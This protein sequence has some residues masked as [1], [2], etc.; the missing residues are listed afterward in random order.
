MNLFYFKLFIFFYVN[1]YSFVL[2]SFGFWFIFLR[3][4]HP[5][6]FISEHCLYLFLFFPLGSYHSILAYNPLSF[7]I[8]LSFIILIRSYYPHKWVLFFNYSMIFWGLSCQV[9]FL[10]KDLDSFSKVNIIFL[11]S[12]IIVVQFWLIKRF[13][14]YHPYLSSFFKSFDFLLLMT[15][16]SFS[17]LC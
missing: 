12:F 3:I 2:F 7:C 1:L 11:F 4:I 15:H 8:K 5:F 17:Y 13:L 14:V 16:V 6:E 10:L 9:W